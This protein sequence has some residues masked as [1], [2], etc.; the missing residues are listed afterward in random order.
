MKPLPSPIIPRE[1]SSSPADS[2]RK[3]NIANILSK[4]NRGG[5]L[6]PAEIKMLDGQEDEPTLTCRSVS[7][8]PRSS[9]PVL[10]SIA[11]TASTLGVP[12]AL[13][14]RA[15]REGSLAFLAGSRVD[16]HILIPKLFSMLLVKKG[17]ESDVLDPQ[18]EKAKLD[19]A[20]RRE[21]E[22]E[23]KL[24]RSEMHILEDVEK[25]VWSDTLAPARDGIMNLSRICALQCNPQDV[26]TATRVLDAYA[27]RILKTINEAVPPE[28]KEE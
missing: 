2:A 3:K 27:A 22:D 13:V 5:I 24:R 15:K 11:Q 7:G 4:Q 19:A 21:I 20:R 26:A 1:Q 14:K 9:F 16:T 18:Q 25:K 10:E 28:M 17:S 6:T 12:V 23:E 8:R